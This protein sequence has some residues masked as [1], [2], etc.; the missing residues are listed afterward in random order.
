MK[1]F[2]SFKYR[3]SL[4]DVLEIYLSTVVCE[5]AETGRNVFE[6]GLVLLTSEI[7]IYSK[8]CLIIPFFEIIF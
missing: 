7:G 3:K 6:K 1:K 5:F 8:N 2:A 4:F